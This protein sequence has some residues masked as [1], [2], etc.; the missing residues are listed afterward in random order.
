MVD[1]TLAY[2][3]PEIGQ[4]VILLTNQAM[5]VKDLDHYLL[6]LMQC[7][8]NGVIIDEVAKFLAP[9]SSETMDAIQLDYSF[10]DIHPII[11]PLK[12]NTVTRYFEVNTPT[13]EEY[14]DQNIKIEIMM[15]APPWDPSSPEFTMQEES[16]F[17]YREQFVS[18]NT[19]SRGQLF[20]NS[21]TSYAYDAADVMYND[22][23]ATLLESFVSTSSLKV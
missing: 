2:T 19:P 23:C 18:P 7:C 12:S 13:Q 3:E 14:I 11:I 22:S 21:V 4:V 16:M 17:N 8:M 15:N 20:I 1:T 10:D 9:I 5:A 6:C